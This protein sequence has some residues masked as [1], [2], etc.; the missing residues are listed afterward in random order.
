MQVNVS[1]LRSKVEDA[2]Y[3]ATIA[4]FSTA[5]VV[6]KAALAVGARS[7]QPSLIDYLR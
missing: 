6:Y 4:N 5:E 2:D 1:E 3:T 7:I